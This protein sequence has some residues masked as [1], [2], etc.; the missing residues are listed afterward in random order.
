MIRPPDARFLFA[1]GEQTK[2]PNGYADTGGKNQ[3][4]TIQHTA[5][6]FNFGCMQQCWCN[7]PTASR[8]GNMNRA[9]YI[10]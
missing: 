5:Q 7:I 2:N 3:L 10:L 8:A 4:H 6:R 1:I 9:T